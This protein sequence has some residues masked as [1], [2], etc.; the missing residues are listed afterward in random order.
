MLCSLLPYWQ[1]VTG[2]AV[3]INDLAPMPGELHAAFVVTQE[4]NAHIKSIDTSAALVGFSL[5]YT[6]QTNIW[7]VYRNHP[8]R[9]FV[10]PYIMSA[11][12]PLNRW[13]DIGDTSRSCSIYDLRMCIKQDNPPPKNIKGDNTRE[14][15]ICAWRGHPLGFWLTVLVDSV[16]C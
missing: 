1:Q 12:I 10:L 15:I 8:V 5:L 4:G 3:F 14:I 9:P 13:T 6:P 2:E 7:A 11:E 16:Y